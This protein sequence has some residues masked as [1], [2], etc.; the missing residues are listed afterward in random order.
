V[1]CRY[2]ISFV[3]NE[4]RSAFLA[5]E[6]RAFASSA[7]FLGTIYYFIKNIEKDDTKTACMSL[8]VCKGQAAIIIQTS[9]MTNVLVQNECRKLMQQ[10]ILCVASSAALFFN[11]TFID[12]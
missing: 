3:R 9:T 2:D 8:Q 12:R 4:E 10:N 7:Y 1:F 11:N 5:E 6:K